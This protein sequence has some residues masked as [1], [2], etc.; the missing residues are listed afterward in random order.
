MHSPMLSP[1]LPPRPLNHAR[2][3]TTRPTN[4]LSA[5][6]AG[7]S[8]P[9][10]TALIT[11]LATMLV[12]FTASCGDDDDAD[13][14][15]DT[16]TGTDTNDTANTDDDD[17]NTD[18]TAS[19]DDDDS[20][21]D[22][23]DDT[24]P[25]VTLPDATCAAETFVNPPTLAPDE[26]GV[27][28]LTLA[29]TEVTLDGKRHC[30]RAYNGAIPGPTID[31][32]PRNA[33][34]PRQVR[35]NLHNRFT[36]HDFH[37]L[38][39][40][41]CTCTDTASNE[42]CLPVMGGH[43]HSHNEGEHTSGDCVC[44]ADDGSTCHMFDFNITNL[45]AHGSHV[46]PDYATGGGC[47]ETDTLRCR[48]CTSDNTGPRT[49]F[50][51]DD[52]ITQ[53]PP[54]SGVQHRL[55]LDEDGTH[56][57]GLQWY[58]PH[59]HGT[60]AIQVASGAAGAL[61]VRGPLDEAPGIKDAKERIIVFNTPPLGENGF[62]PLEDGQTCNEETLT[63]NDFTRLTS[64]DAKQ[65]NLINGLR[66]PRMLLPP[67]QIER[68]RLLHAGFLD[69]VYLALLPGTDANCTN[70]D[71][72][73]PFTLTQI[74]RDGLTLTRP[75]NGNEWPYAPNYFFMSPGYRIEAILDGS[76]LDDGDTLCMVAVRFLQEN[77]N[78]G[79][80]TEGPIGM[81]K[82][83]TEDEL[84]AKFKAGDLVAIV[85]VTDAAAPATQTTL[86]DFAA[87]AALAPSTTLGD[88]TSVY[89]RCD[90]AKGPKPVESLEQVVAFQIGLSLEGPDNCGCSD[91]NI[92]CQNFEHVNR[93]SY[94]F[95]RVLKKD[96]IE[97]WRVFSAFDGHPFHIHINPYFV[98][99]LPEKGSPEPNALGRIFEPPFGHWRDT[100]LVNLA[101][102]ADV[103]TEY[104]KHTGTFVFHCHK[105]THEDH[106]MMELM[107]VCDPDTEPCDTLCDGRE[108]TW[109]TCAEGDDECRRQWFAT[110]C[111][112]T[113]DCVEAP[114]W[115]SECTDDPTSCPKGSICSEQ[116]TYDDARRCI[117]GCTT[118]TDCPPP[119]TCTNGTCTGPGG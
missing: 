16:D 47:V 17:S 2:F 22:D 26:N 91:H 64:T 7:A 38:N 25:C 95:D 35:I 78:E 93:D 33:A 51:A 11:A 14:S 67:G 29:P 21:S 42:S 56:H 74:A 23:D 54:D 115:C 84:K 70:W 111:V 68:W 3:E 1:M 103:I 72:S 41:S 80:L 28:N 102:Y 34:E 62:V 61:I 76:K 112:L 88:G 44:K 32:A 59:I 48:P 85:N 36:A 107:H 4:R 100:Y 52:V 69:E 9:R 82:A 27:Y 6:L 101:R 92:N 66:R 46:R 77:P 12:L 53:V 118:N 108:C 55:D 71:T 15:T 86:P 19:S 8:A 116:T 13:T 60:T 83:P 104:R 79:E 109:D 63:F 43:T 119:Q 94:P 5:S 113:G 105:L 81:T 49:C 106:G 65:T 18:D 10:V 37:D 90:A 50:L 87:L 75:P 96:S 89:D 31:V 24:A 45:H 99:P 97:H 39:G 73:A 110:K 40:K 98:C 57:E 114:L 117:P 58:H 20:N 30:V